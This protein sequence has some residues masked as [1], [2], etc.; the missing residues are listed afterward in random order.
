MR[1]TLLLIRKSVYDLPH[2]EKEIKRVDEKK[3]HLL[4]VVENPMASVVIL[5]IGRMIV[6]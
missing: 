3:L 5:R 1:I 6:K 4:A 2:L